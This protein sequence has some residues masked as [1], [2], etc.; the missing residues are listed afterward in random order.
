MCLPKNHSYPTVTETGKP[1]APAWDTEHYVCI[2]ALV[3]T[4]TSL[5]SLDVPGD[6]CSKD[7]SLWNPPASG[8]CHCVAVTDETAKQ[9]AHGVSTGPGLVLD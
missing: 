3:T 5:C 9:D 6:E 1:W 7:M 8:L 2:P 4:A